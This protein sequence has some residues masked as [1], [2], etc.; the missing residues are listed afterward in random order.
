[1][2]FLLFPLLRMRIKRKRRGFAR[3]R[4]DLS[5]RLSA[6]AEVRTVHPTHAVSPKS[7]SAANQAYPLMQ[8]P[9]SV[10]RQQMANS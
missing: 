10:L 8:Q 6:H 3:L 7:E 1:M 9:R 5:V 2:N 4:R